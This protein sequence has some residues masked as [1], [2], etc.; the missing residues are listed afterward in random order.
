M[1][2]GLLKKLVRL[3]NSNPNEHEANSAARRVCKLIE[4]GKFEFVDSKQNTPYQYTYYDEAR[5]VDFNDIV[6]QMRKVR[7]NYRRTEPEFKAKYE[8]FWSDEYI[9]WKPN[10]PK[11]NLKCKTCLQTIE[12]IFVGAPE[13][14]ECNNCIWTEWERKRDGRNN[15]VSP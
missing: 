8:G 14:F 15:P 11:R 4:E 5:S 12:T 13:V 10:K 3:A 1:N 9:K 7:Y 2:L 6:E